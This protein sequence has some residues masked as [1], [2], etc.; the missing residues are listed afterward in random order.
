MK[1]KIAKPFKI[2]MCVGLFIL[3]LLDIVGI[4]IN[5]GI[6]DTGSYFRFVVNMP[7]SFYVVTSIFSLFVNAYILYRVSK[8]IKGKVN[9]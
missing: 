1:N 3:V 6:I 4:S 7:G 8:S 2:L 9:G 5:A